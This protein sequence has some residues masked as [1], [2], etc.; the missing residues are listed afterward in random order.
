MHR[1][2][3]VLLGLLAACDDAKLIATGTTPA[4]DAANAPDGAIP[5]DAA[6]PQDA[7]TP[8]GP[9][10]AGVVAPLDPTN[11]TPDGWC[12]DMPTPNGVGWRSVWVASDNEAWAVGEAGLAYH[13]LNGTW[14]LVPTGTPSS[15]SV[16]YGFSANDVWA[17]G[18]NGVGVHWD[19]TQWSENGVSPD[20]QSIDTLWGIN[21]SLWAGSVVSS[22]PYSSSYSV[23]MDSFNGT[24]WKFN[25]SNCTSAL[26]SIWGASPSD[27]WFT[28]DGQ[29]FEHF[30]GVGLT[31]VSAGVTPVAGLWGTSSTSI[32]ALGSSNAL[33]HYDGASW[34]VASTPDKP[35]GALWGTSDSDFWSINGSTALHFSSGTQWTEQALPPVA[36]I[37]TVHGSSATNV[38]GV[39]GYNSLVH[40]DGAAWTASPAA[41][42]TPAPAATL[43]AIWASGANDAW[44]TGNTTLS[45]WDGQNLTTVVSGLPHFLSTIQGA[46]ADDVWACGG[47]LVMH[48]DGNAWTDRSPTSPIKIWHVWPTGNGEGFGTDDGGNIYR[49]TAAAGWVLSYTVPSGSYPNGP[50]GLWGT[51]PNDVWAGGGNGIAHWNGTSWSPL[52]GTNAPKSASMIWGSGPNDVYV[53]FSNSVTHYNGSSWTHIPDLDSRYLHNV[54]QSGPD[55]IWLLDYYL[56]PNA[57]CRASHWDGASWKS[58][59]LPLA[60]CGGVATAGPHLVWVVGDGNQLVHMRH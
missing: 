4:T 45:H 1:V 56:V 11:C 23:E 20:G 18:A 55:D 42:M 52:T 43:Y 60:S 50:N 6:S 34:Q 17:A 54:A 5:A 38:W 7:A 53:S 35:L 25:F 26:T 10:D 9:P 29:G 24:A 40:Y 2:C 33:L 22:F 13:Y 51:G 47:S 32:W 44:I 3:S 15:L 48:Y 14:T 12:W 36:G 19:G 30:D 39:G 59:W 16:V 58:Y 27:V 8:D 41:T 49:Y 37:G 57:P 21:G 46:A 28:C 31:T